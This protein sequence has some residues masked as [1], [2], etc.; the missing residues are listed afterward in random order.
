MK[1]LGLVS[2]LGLIVA[3]IIIIYDCVHDKILFNGGRYFYINIIEIKR[4]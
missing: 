3:I 1:F 2:I 4:K